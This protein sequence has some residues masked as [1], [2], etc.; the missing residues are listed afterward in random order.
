[1]SEF[2]HKYREPIFIT[3][4][5][6]GD[7]AVMSIETYE[8]LAGKSELYKL[9]QEGIDDIENGRTLTEKEIINN[10]EKALGK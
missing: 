2:C 9:I 10:M 3:K 5:G 6:E 1:M 8:E 4:N 7:L